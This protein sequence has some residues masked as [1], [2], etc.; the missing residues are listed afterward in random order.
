MPWGFYRTYK[1]LKLKEHEDILE[2][3][4]SFYRTYK[5]LKQMMLRYPFYSVDSSFYRT[6]KEL[7]P[8]TAAGLALMKSGFYR[9]YKELKHLRSK[10]PHA[11]GC[12]RFYR[13]Y[14]ELKQEIRWSRYSRSIYVFIVPIRNWNTEEAHAWNNS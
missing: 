2:I 6:Y 4:A 9:T 7:K 5:E 11:P 13:T 12:P 1:E 8:S 3:Y 14:K 10:S